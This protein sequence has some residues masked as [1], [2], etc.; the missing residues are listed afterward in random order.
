MMLRAKVFTYGDLDS[1]SVWFSLKVEKE[2]D[3]WV[4]VAVSLPFSLGKKL[5]FPKSYSGWKPQWTLSQLVE[6]WGSEAWEHFFQPTNCSRWWME[7]YRRHTFLAWPP[8]CLN[9]YSKEHSS[10]Y[11]EAV[12]SGAE[13]LPSYQAWFLCGTPT[14]AGF[15]SL[16]LYTCGVWGGKG[17]M[18]L[19]Q[20]LSL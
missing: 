2:G 6:P 10:L 3:L 19:C 9:L 13:S 11:S 18:C 16:D 1:L 17:W 4:S 14:E 7:N 12:L 8:P 5:A 15:H 20:C